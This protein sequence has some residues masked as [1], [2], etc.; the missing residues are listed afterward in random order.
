MTPKGGQYPPPSDPILL[1]AA[2]LAQPLN[3]ELAAI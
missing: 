2:A 1:Q 3:T